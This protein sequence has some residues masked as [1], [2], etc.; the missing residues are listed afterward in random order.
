MDLRAEMGMEVL[1]VQEEEVVPHT[2]I[3]PQVHQ[4]IEI[5][6]EILKHSIILT[7]TQTL[8]V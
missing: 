4:L 3:Q 5:Q 8:E 7:G 6:M 2:L 1:E